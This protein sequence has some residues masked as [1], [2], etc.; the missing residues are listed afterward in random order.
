ME[1]FSLEVKNLKVTTRE[2]LARP[3]VNLWQIVCFNW[4]RDPWVGMSVVLHERV[5]N[6]RDECKCECG[7]LAAP[8]SA[9][10][11][12]KKC[13]RC[14]DKWIEILPAVELA[15]W[16]VHSESLMDCSDL[17]DRKGAHTL[18]CRTLQRPFWR[19]R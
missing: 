19:L 14:Q 13:W 6:A 4:C 8:A 3:T 1:N 5:M 9:I 11:E 17:W 16:E 18:P 7:F 12:I 2:P 15:G 10:I